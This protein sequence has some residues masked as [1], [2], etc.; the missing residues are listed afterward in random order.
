MVEYELM[1]IS[2]HFDVSF[3]QRNRLLTVARCATKH[4]QPTITSALTVIALAS[5]VSG[6]RVAISEQPVTF[7]VVVVFG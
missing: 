1:L 5:F 7:A 3:G 6:T 4:P 2:I